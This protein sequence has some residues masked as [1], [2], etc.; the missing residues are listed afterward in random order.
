M[1][2]NDRACE[3]CHWWR[4][5]RETLPRFKRADEVLGCEI[6]DPPTWAPSGSR[7]GDDDCRV[8]ILTSVERPG[9]CMHGPL[10][11]AATGDRLR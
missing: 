6:E 3:V 11:S 4:P 8:V 1:S 7:C 5:C 10:F 2:N 9:L